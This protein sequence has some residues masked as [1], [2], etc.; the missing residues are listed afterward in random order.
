MALFLRE[1]GG[2]RLEQNGIKIMLRRRGQ[3]AGVANMHAHRLRHTLAHEWQVNGGNETD[4]MAIMGWES[5]EMLRR[6]GRS[7]A[8][9]RAHNSHRMLRL[10][11]RV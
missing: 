7:A 3:A 1:R 9:V 6:Y 8:A 2:Q 4:L 11:N 10:G 5:P